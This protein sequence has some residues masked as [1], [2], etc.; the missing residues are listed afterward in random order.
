M[1]QGWSSSVAQ[2]LAEWVTDQQQQRTVSAYEYSCMH[3]GATGAEDCC[4]PLIS[5]SLALHQ[6]CVVLCMWCCLLLL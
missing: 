3:V 5:R 6:A 2:S 1:E 4:I